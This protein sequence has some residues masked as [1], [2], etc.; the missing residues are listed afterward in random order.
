[1]RAEAARAEAARAEA[2]RA[3]AARAAAAASN[4]PVSFTAS[5]ANW[6]S[7]PRFEFPSRAARSARSG[8]TFRVVLRM[9]VNKQGGIDS[10]SVATSSGNAVVDREAQRQARSGRFKPFTKNG[11]PVVGNV[12]LP[13]SY[14]VP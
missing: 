10:V 9:R 2:A 4:T 8:D 5:N 14:E 13:V 1:A 6:A 7:R 3:E 11:V 12:T